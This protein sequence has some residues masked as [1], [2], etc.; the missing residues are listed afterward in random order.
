MPLIT[1]LTQTLVDTR[2]GAGIPYGHWYSIEESYAGPSGGLSYENGSAFQLTYITPWV[3]HHRFCQLILGENYVAS[4]GTR[5]R[6]YRSLPHAYPV[7]GYTNMFATNITS[8]SG[9]PGPDPYEYV[10]GSSGAF[11]RRP[12]FGAV[13]NDTSI[14]KLLKY[15]YA[16]VTVQYGPYPYPVIGEDGGGIFDDVAWNKEWLRFTT[17]QRTPRVELLKI[18]TGVLKWTTAPVEVAPIDL[19]VRDQ[20]VDYVVTWHRVPFVISDFDQFIGFSNAYDAA[21]GDEALNVKFLDGHPQ[22]PDGGFVADRLLL[23]G[24][25][26]TLIPQP[27]SA[28]FG[29][30]QLYTYAFFF[31]DKF[32]GHNAALRLKNIGQATATATYEPYSLTGTV[33]VAGVTENNKRAIKQVAMGN[34]FLPR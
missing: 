32:N 17:V 31:Q 26:E 22:V 4:D 12:T 1:D 10:E 7:H 15:A 11:I 16:K 20:S 6:L 28:D 14:G 21:S 25:Q 27:W 34:L 18:K 9:V 29:V 19:P 30:N 3:D 8:V 24:V 2:Q 23:V 33:P 13:D 5:N